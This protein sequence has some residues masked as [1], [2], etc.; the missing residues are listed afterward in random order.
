MYASIFQF[1]N[2][3]LNEW[4]P[5]NV[6]LNLINLDYFFANV[7]GNV[8]VLSESNTAGAN[9]HPLPAYHRAETEYQGN[10]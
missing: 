2:I 3:L 5:I 8:V 10:T 6:L 7:L 4:K 1:T 9:E